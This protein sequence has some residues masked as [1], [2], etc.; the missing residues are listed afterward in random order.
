MQMSE[1]VANEMSSNSEGRLEFDGSVIAQ[2]ARLVMDALC[3]T[4]PS[5]LS[6]FAK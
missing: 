4:W 3:D 6:A 2:T 1:D 5:E